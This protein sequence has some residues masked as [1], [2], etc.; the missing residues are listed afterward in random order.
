M[1]SVK[2]EDEPLSK[3]ATVKIKTHFDSTRS[4][5]PRLLKLDSAGGKQRR[6]TVGTQLS[7]KEKPVTFSLP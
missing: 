7:P 1:Q 2:V 3:E 5:S 6:V 4:K